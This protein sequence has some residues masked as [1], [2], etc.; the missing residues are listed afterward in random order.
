MIATTYDG[1]AVYLVTERPEWSQRDTGTFTLIGNAESSLSNRESRR[2]YDDLI[3]VALK[4]TA[5]VRDAEA[6]ALIGALRT[7]KQQPVALPFWPGEQFWPNRAA[8]PWTGGLMLAW[9]D[10]WSQWEIYSAADVAAHTEPT[11]PTSLT[12]WAPLL[13]GFLKPDQDSRWLAPSLQDWAVEFA[14]ASPAAW[15]LQP[16]TGSWSAGPLPPAGY[17]NAPDL[18]PTRPRFA[19]V[20][21]TLT[22]RVSRTQT[23]F[24]R[25]PSTTFYPQAVAQICGQGFQLTDMAAIA[26]LVAFY[27]SHGAAAS[28][29]VSAAFACA[30]LTA[31]IADGDTVIDVADTAMVSTGDYVALIDAAGAIVGRRVTD[32]TS[33]TLTLNSAPGARTAAATYLAPLLLCRW[34]DNQLEVEW[35]HGNLATAKTR[36]REVPAEYS[37]A[38]DETLAGSLGELPTRALLYQFTQT[39]GATVTTWRY[40][41]FREDVTDATPNTWASAD[42]A[43]GDLRRSLNLER[44][45]LELISQIFTGNPLLPF[46][47][48]N[49]EARLAIRI[50]E[51]DVDGAD[52]DNVTPIFT[53]EVTRIGRVGSKL[54]PTL[55]PQGRRMDQLVPAVVR[56]LQCPWMVYSDG[57]GLDRDDW[58]FTAHVANPVSSAWPFELNLATLARVVGSPPTFFVDWFAGGW[59]EWGT[60]A[61]LQRRGIL[62]STNPVSNALTLTLSRWW[63]GTAPAAGATVRIWPGCDK[64]AS[65]C[66]AYNAGNN[67]RGKFDNY[68][69]ASPPTGGGVGGK[70]FMPAGNPAST[71]NASGGSAGKK[72]S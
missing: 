43:H 2:A 19:E 9:K 7:L 11:W 46:I 39:L 22:V 71:Q 21:H 50:S 29:W 34:D 17:S 53:G 1:A 56:G 8:A 30:K 54:T 69:P 15:A 28:F 23:G 25:E 60:G 26:R 12:R 13:W 52:V 48:L 66:K 47:T 55:T 62:T 40:T 6:R 36:L 63:T 61:D 20:D 3:R 68:R 4:Y 24:R 27:G 59:I 38:A 31:D 5:R 44:D 72:G 37:P 67:P 65:T 18:F 41:S 32:K 35:K 51:A 14:E 58:E 16:A 45:E 10:D 42:F 33:T 64:L 49:A 70:P 57:C